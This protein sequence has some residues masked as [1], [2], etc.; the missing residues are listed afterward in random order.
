MLRILILFLFSSNLFS[1]SL[2]KNWVLIDSINTHLPE[3][4]QLFEGVSESPPLRAW[5]VIVDE[6]NPKIYSDI[7]ISEDSDRKEN[8]MDFAKRLNAKVV[9]NGGYFNMKA[10]P[11]KHAGLFIDNGKLWGNATTKRTRNNIRYNFLRATF[12]IDDAGRPDIFWADNI[13]KKIRVFE[14][15]IKNI[16]GKPDSSFNYNIGKLKTF[17]DALG[18]GPMLVQNGKMKIASDEELFFGTSIPKTHPRSAVGITKDGKTIYLVVDGRQILSRGVNLEELANILLDIGA[19]EAMNL[20]GGGSSTLV[21]NGK[22]I[23]RPAGGTYLREVMSAIAIF[24]D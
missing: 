22:L 18:A 24:A 9:I 10:N 12:A 4:I 14:T 11:C 1:Q 7:V 5:Y 13:K 20:D 19:Y 21:V 6:P 17:K 3:G 23:N 15:P 2:I 8:I 16:P